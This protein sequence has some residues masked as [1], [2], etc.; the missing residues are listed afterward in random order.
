MS[1]NRSV[2]IYGIYLSGAWVKSFI[3]DPCDAFVTKG[4]GMGFESV[5]GVRLSILYD[6]PYADGQ[7]ATAY[8]PNKS[9]DEVKA[10][11]AKELE[12]DYVVNDE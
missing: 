2:D 3:V 11:V 5:R 6:S 8:I 1:I 9:I 4:R 12:V 10:E 7:V